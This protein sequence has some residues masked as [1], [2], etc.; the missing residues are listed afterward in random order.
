MAQ[1]VSV[2]K[3]EMNYHRNWAIGNREQITVDRIP[4]S[5]ETKFL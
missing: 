2:L 3:D 4:Y 1:K 5:T